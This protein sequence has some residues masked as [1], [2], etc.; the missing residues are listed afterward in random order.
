M[1]P[2]PSTAL[3]TEIG[4]A[5]L[6]SRQFRRQACTIDNSWIDRLIAGAAGVF[7]AAVGGGALFRSGNNDRVGRRRA[8]HDAALVELYTAAIG[9]GQTFRT[10]VQMQPKAERQIG[11]AVALLR[12][13]S[14]IVGDPTRLFLGDR[15][16][17]AEA[18][19]RAPSGRALRLG[20]LALSVLVRIRLVVA[21]CARRGVCWVRRRRGEP[22][23]GPEVLPDALIVLAQIVP[24]LREVVAGLDEPE[25]T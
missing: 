1:W 6:A 20:R 15:S 18:L 7:G 19:S 16:G 5:R 12:L 17:T 4:H 9:L 23:S 8:D 13:A 3:A 25:E 22:S 11:R 10:W 24:R 14:K 21:S 2:T